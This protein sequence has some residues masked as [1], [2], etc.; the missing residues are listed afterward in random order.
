M[1]ISRSTEGRETSRRIATAGLYGTSGLSL[2]KLAGRHEGSGRG[3]EKTS[4]G[5]SASYSLKASSAAASSELTLCSNRI[6]AP[7]RALSA[8]VAESSAT[9]ASSFFLSLAVG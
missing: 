2:S 8:S 9:T 1:I 3:N 7:A 4:S 5:V 6:T